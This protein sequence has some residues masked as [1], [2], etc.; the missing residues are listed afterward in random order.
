M[1]DSE[2]MTMAELYREAYPNYPPLAVHD[3]W[4]IGVWDLGNNYKGSGFYGSYPNGYLRRVMCMFP[5]AKQV[6]HLFSGSLPPGPYTRF[7]CHE[8]A[9]VIG[10]AHELSRHCYTSCLSFDLVLADPPYTKEDAARYGTPM[11]HRA[12]IM[13]E[14]AKVTY[15]GGWLVWLDTV[16]PMYRK[17]EWIL[18]V[19]VAVVGSTNHRVRMAFFFQR[20]A[21]DEGR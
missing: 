6:L 18:R 3:K 4:L 5:D 17:C 16:K 19:E 21:N 8:P 9:D 11:V 7:D 2:L 12:K 13:R 20:N 1:E 15:S 14:V 10:D